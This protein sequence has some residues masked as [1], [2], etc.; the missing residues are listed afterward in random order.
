MIRIPVTM[1]KNYMG[2][3]K[4]YYALLNFKKVLIFTCFN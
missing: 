3:F 2:Y 1:D 4:I